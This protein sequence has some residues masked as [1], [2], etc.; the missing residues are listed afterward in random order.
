MSPLR[1]FVPSSGGGDGFRPVER[2][3]LVQEDEVFLES[4]NSSLFDEIVGAIED[5]V[6]DERFQDVQSDILEKYFHHF[7]V[8]III[9][10]SYFY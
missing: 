10:P 5:I 4:E 2:N 7:D 1:D 8:S 3:M 9:L 6:V